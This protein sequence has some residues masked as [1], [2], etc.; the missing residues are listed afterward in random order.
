MESF[1][2]KIFRFLAILLSVIFT[3]WGV[4]RYFSNF[5]AQGHNRTLVIGHSHSSCSINDTLIP[6][7]INRSNPGEAYL[8]NFFKTRELLKQ[9]PEIENLL[10]EFSNDQL[11]YDIM[12]QWIWGDDFLM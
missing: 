5:S 1:V 2:S 10:I 12:S 7:L 4:N 6:G 9:N 11:D 3:I 8:Y